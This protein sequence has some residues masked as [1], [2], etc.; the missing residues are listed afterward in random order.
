MCGKCGQKLENLFCKSCDSEIKIRQHILT[1]FLIGAFALQ[2]E[3]RNLVTNDGGYFSTYFPELNIV[4]A[5]QQ[6]PPLL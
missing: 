1:E 3:G 4:T 2:M 5:Y 6:A